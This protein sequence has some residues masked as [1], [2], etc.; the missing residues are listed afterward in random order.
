VKIPSKH[1]VIGLLAIGAV[2]LLSFLV[3]WHPGRSHDA[4]VER[5]HTAAAKVKAAEISAK[6]MRVDYKRDT[7]R[8]APAVKKQRAKKDVY[9]AAR[10]SALENLAD[11]ALVKTALAAADS[12]IAAGDTVAAAATAV[13]SSSASALD[14][15]DVVSAAKDTLQSATAALIPSRFQKAVTAGKW[16]VV[17][18]VAV[19]SVSWI[20]EHVAVHR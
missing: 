8:V 17:T 13:V 2:C 3:I 4:N 5:Q 20:L 18:I 9:I 12:A 6:K 7:A 14:A 19:K 1:D 16:V 15:T 11:T 10:D